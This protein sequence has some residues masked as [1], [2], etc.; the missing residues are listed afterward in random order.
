ME[1]SESSAASAPPPAV[2]G[3]W[4]EEYEIVAEGRLKEII[5]RN[6]KLISALYSIF[7]WEDWYQEERKSSLKMVAFS[8]ETYFLS[9]RKSNNE[10]DV[11][12]RWILRQAHALS[13]LTLD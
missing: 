2:C 9:C 7:E 11:R 12:C 1:I 4:M 6:K 3:S 8:K 5:R 10:G 13:E